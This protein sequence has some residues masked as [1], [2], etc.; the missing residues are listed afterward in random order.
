VWRFWVQEFA[1]G[2]VLTLSITLR[3]RHQA[4]RD[5]RDLYI[6]YIYNANNREILTIRASQPTGERRIQEIDV[7][8]L[9]SLS[10]VIPSS[11]VHYM[12][13]TSGRKFA[14][15]AAKTEKG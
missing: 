7:H 1:R 8:S 15:K 3:D 11:T 14:M 5:A 13:R 4:R 10:T 12:L 2:T 6:L 9:V